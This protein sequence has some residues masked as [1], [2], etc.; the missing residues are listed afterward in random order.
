M[1]ASR[2][3]VRRETSIPLKHKD[4]GKEWALDKN[5]NYSTFLKEYPKCPK[6]GVI[7]IG[8]GDNIPFTKN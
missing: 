8:K 2:I 6:K 7:R 4:K 1:R 3:V 5:D